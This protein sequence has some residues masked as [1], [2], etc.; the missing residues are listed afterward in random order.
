MIKVVCNDGK[1]FNMEKEM[2]DNFITIKNSLEH[3]TDT[4]VPLSNVDGETFGKIVEFY[5]FYM[6][7]ADGLDMSE[8]DQKEWNKRFFEINEELTAKSLQAAIF[9]DCSKFLNAGV[10]YVADEIRGKTPAEIRARFNIPNDWTP[11]EEEELEKERKWIQE[12][13]K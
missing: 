9:L 11:E 7:S 12:C 6:N 4:T 5:D 13:M 8:K 2:I 3:S 1:E 10:E